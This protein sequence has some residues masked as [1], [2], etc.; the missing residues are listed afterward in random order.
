MD[1]LPNLKMSD[2][3]GQYSVFTVI[4][5][6]DLVKYTVEVFNM[7]VNTGFLVEEE[8]Y[9]GIVVS[10]LIE[11]HGYGALSRISSLGH[12]ITESVDLPYFQIYSIQESEIVYIA[13]DKIELVN[14][15]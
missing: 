2:F 5:K 1:G 8:K 6:G 15:D 4:K 7:H 13:C 9:L 11:T 12:P 10:D 3:D 14:T